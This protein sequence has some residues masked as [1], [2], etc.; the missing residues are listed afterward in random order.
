MNHI[1]K[2]VKRCVQR[3]AI[4]ATVIGFAGC[5]SGSSSSSLPQTTQLRAIH[6]SS[7][8]PNVDVIVNG[9]SVATNVPYKAASQFFTIPAGTTKV[10]VNPTGTSTS[11]INVS[12]SLLA[13]HQYT[14]IAAGYA[15][16][17][18]PTAQAIAP[19]LVDD[20]GNSPQSGNVKLRVVHGAP[21]APAVDIYVTAP[22]APLPS[23]PTVPALSYSNYAPAAG[24]KALEVAGG[25]YEIR[26]TLAGTST[27]VFDSGSAALPA[28][29]DLLVTAIPATGVSPISLLVAPSGANAFVI[30]DTHAAVRVAHFSPNVPAVNVFL[31]APGQANSNSDQVLSNFT[32]PSASAYLRVPNG[33]YNASVSLYPDTTGVLNLNGANLAANSNTSVFAIGLLNGTGAQALQLAAYVDDRSPV[34]GKAKVRV[35]HLSPDAPAVDVVALSGGNIAAT[36]VSNLAYP[37]ATATSLQ[38]AP[39]A[40]TLAVV[41]HGATTPILPSS[42]GVNVTLTSGQVLTV[43]A[44]GCLNTTTGACS[45]GQPFAFTVLT[46][47]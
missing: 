4:A 15:A 28:N 33:T 14:A 9:N 7:D 11:V 38:V 34:P 17:S 30:A 43:A 44:V 36:L 25:N 24:V 19:I 31:G 26:V 5:S 1:I 39:G 12:P 18:A 20:P 3:L 32:F 8:A 6:A 21:A 37:N 40:Y 22:G 2:N 10:Q 46:D 13:S 47:N 45:G 23:S 41:P 42:A 16:P 27:V 35:I 29:A